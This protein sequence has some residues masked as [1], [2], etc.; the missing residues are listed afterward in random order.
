MIDLAITIATPLVSFP[1]M[2]AI[3]GALYDVRISYARR[4]RDRLR[5]ARLGLSRE[6]PGGRRQ[7]IEVIR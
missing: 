1:L 7:R 6:L 2:L 3:G 5:R 4:R